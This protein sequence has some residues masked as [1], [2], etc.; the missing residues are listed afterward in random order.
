MNIQ[1]IK[2]KIENDE[3]LNNIASFFPNEIYLVGGSVRDY[4]LGKTTFDRD[5]IVVDEDAK[6]FAEKISEFF[7]AA[8]VPLDE[9]NKIYRVVMP[10]KLNFLDITNPVENSLEKDIMRR[11]MTINSLAANIRTGEIIDLCGGV[12][13]LHNKIIRGVRDENFVDDPLRLLR[14]FRFYS[15]LGFQIDK[16]LLDIIKKHSGLIFKPAKERVQYELMKL[17]SGKYADLAL[18]KMD[19]CGI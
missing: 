16:H 13:D 15:L 8:F 19:E 9:I 2:N 6:I 4:F 10:D 18:L 17:F 1:S 14:V 12:A 5:L 11:D 3:I 7:A